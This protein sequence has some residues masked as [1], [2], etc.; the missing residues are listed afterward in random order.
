MN[1]D[2]IRV[3]SAALSVDAEGAAFVLCFA[4]VGKLHF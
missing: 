4:D 2:M 3:V 1:W